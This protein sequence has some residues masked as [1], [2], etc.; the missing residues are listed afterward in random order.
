MYT[1]LALLFGSGLGCG[2]S[3]WICA[4]MLEKSNNIGDSHGDSKDYGAAVHFTERINNLKSNDKKTFS[5]TYARN[6]EDKNAEPKGSEQVRRLSQEELENYELTKAEN[7]TNPTAY[8]GNQI[9]D[10]EDEFKKW[11]QQQMGSEENSK[12]IFKPLDNNKF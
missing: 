12:P 6:I 2:L 1:F 4:T 11:E 10:S 8:T 3:F 9:E 5:I 7:M